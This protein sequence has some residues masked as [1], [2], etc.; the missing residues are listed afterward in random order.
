MRLLLVLLLAPAPPATVPAARAYDAGRLAYERGDYAT[1]RAQ[2]ELALSL[3]PPADPL[4]SP[5]TY[6]LARTV[7][8]Q[9]APCEALTHLRSYLALSAGDEGEARRR[10]KARAAVEE[11]EGACA[12]QRAALR[13]E[14]VAEPPLEPISDPIVGAP[15]EP[16]PARSWWPWI[17]A[18]GTLVTAAVGLGFGATARG[19]V[20]DAD[21]AYARYV[22]GGRRD[23]DARAAVIDAR[24]QADADN[25][26]SYTFLAV[27]GALAGV[28]TWLF[29]TEPAVG[30]GA[31]VG[32]GGGYV[33]W[34]FE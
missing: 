26:L 22:D 25:A 24:D 3:L 7:Q 29:W 18:G 27:A 13:P 33:E 23:R 15:V 10:A 6:N 17:A 32:P 9:S 31:H 2:F 12:A 8:A 14:P 4:R 16:A 34:R 1:A 20:A 11:A 5:T 21:A 30:L 19:H 28:T